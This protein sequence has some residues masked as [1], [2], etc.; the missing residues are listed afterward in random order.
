MMSEDE[1]ITVADAREILG[2][3]KPK[4]TRILKEG[5]LLHTEPNPLDKRSKLLLRSDVEK[6]AAK[7][8]KKSVR[9]AA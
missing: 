6:L 7:L 2:V 9:A 1:Y 3:S 8:P 4:M 5:K